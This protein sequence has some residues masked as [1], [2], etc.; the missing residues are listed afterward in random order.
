MPGHVRDRVVLNPTLSITAVVEAS[1][2]GGGIPAGC[3]LHRGPGLPPAIARRIGEGEPFLPATDILW[4]PR[5]VSGILLPY[6]LTPR[7]AAAVRKRLHSRGVTGERAERQRAV[8]RRRVRAWRIAVR[9]RGYAVLRDPFGAVFV[10]A[11]RAYYRR[12]EAEGHL[13]R[14]ADLR[15]RGRPVLHDEPLSRFLGAQLAPVVAAVTGE[16]TRST[17]SF[18]RVYGPGAVLARHRDR[19]VCRWNVDLVVG[20][21]PAPDRR[22][23]WPLWMG[24]Q[25]RPASLRLALGDA[26]LYRGDRIEHWRGRQPGGRTTVLAALHYGRASTR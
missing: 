20:G 15:R 21:D 5:P 17:F 25:R 3:R 23:A 19:S 2:R 7:G 26:V 10:T 6:T 24:G 1:P 22:G 12:L 8:W 13:A 9:T 18:L 14:G 16:R 11:V 4:M